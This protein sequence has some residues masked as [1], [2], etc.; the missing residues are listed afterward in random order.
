MKTIGPKLC[1][2]RKDS[3]WRHLFQV[4]EWTPRAIYH[5]GHRKFST[6]SQL[7]FPINLM[8]IVTRD[9]F[10]AHLK[11]ADGVGPHV[12]I[13]PRSGKCFASQSDA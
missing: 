3:S 13:L 5:D 8:Q 4:C 1:S 11:A 7:N 6:V 9:I 12:V 10:T 2:Q